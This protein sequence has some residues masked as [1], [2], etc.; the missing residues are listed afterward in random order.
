M[1]NARRLRIMVLTPFMPF[2]KSLGFNIRVF[3]LVRQLA[4]RHQVSVL[5]YGLPANAPDVAAL[6]DLGVEVRVVTPPFPGWG[7]RRVA[8]L[9]S[10]ASG[11]PYQYRELQTPAMQRELDRLLESS[12]F[13]IV[14]VESS[15]VSGFD[16]RGHPI[17]VIDEHNIEYE[18]LSRSYR[19]E[20]SA[21]RKFFSGVEYLKVRRAEQ[22]AWKRA[23]GCLVTSRREE[24]AVRRIAPHVPTAVVSNGVD[25]DYFTPSS[26]APERDSVLFTGQLTYRPNLDAI[27]YFTREILPLIVHVRPS[28]KLTVVGYGPP[29]VLASIT[30]ANVLATGWVPDVRPYLRRAAVV[31][32]PVRMGSGTR[33]KVLDALA[34]GKAV[35]STSLGCEGI[36]VRDGEHLLIGDDPEAFASHA[37]AILRDPLLPGTLARSGRR[38]VE[39]R[40]SWS[41]VTNDLEAFYQRLAAGARPAPSLAG[42]RG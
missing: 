26:E 40:Y 25:L 1:S 21:G 39:D 12:T 18:L 8:Q 19:T 5:T 28:T 10:L 15:P 4:T 9:A 36:E 29:D 16:F 38:L 42:L 35:V 20:R 11:R 41:A 37:L 7:G 17:V 3:Q 22:A 13:D 6:R 24:T 31:V 34:S 32:V 14:Q 30:G 33:L 2:A 23:G 27:R